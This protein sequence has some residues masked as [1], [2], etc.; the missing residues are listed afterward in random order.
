MQLHRLIIPAGIDDP[1]YGY[2]APTSS[3]TGVVATNA[4]NDGINQIVVGHEPLNAFDG[5][6][7]SWQTSVGTQ[8]RQEYMDAMAAA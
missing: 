8:L 6:L 3:G 1:T 7:K 4:M 2:Y 5:L